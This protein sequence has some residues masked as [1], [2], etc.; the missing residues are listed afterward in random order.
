MDE[1]KFSKK[2]M[3]GPVQM[4]FYVSGWKE[5]LRRPPPKQLTR[6]RTLS[7]TIQLTIRFTGPF[8]SLEFQ[9]RNWQFLH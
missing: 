5:V 8:V 4:S 9:C 3:I 7:V 2:C 1:S 6:L